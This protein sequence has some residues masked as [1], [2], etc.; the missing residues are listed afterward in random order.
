MFRTYEPGTGR[1]GL[2]GGISTYGYVSGSPLIRFDVF[3]LEGELGAGG[4]FGGGGASGSWDSPTSCTASNTLPAV[5]EL[6]GTLPVVPHLYGGSLA[7]GAGAATGVAA[8]TLWSAGLNGGDSSVFWSGYAQ[9]ARDV[10]ESLGGTT[11]ESTPIG[12]ALDYLSNTAGV[13]GLGP[14]WSAASATFAGNATGTATAVVF[15]EG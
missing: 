14:V 15:S 6:Y 4:S 2:K 12:S 5:P 9:G 13:P 3:G 8:P 11:L 10:A 7:A 1:I